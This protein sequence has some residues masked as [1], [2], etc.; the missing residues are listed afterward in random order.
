MGLLAKVG[1][2]RP[3]LRAWVAYDWANSA[4]WTTVIAAVFPIYF[5]RVAADGLA[6]EVAAFR[7]GIATTIALALIAFVSPPLGALADAAG[8]KKRMLAVFML[9]GALAT[10]ALV[11]VRTGD[12]LLAL[13]LFMA[14]N[15]GAAGSMTFYD[16][17]LPH[18][19]RPDELDRVSTT[20]Y[21]VGYLGGG[22]LLALNLLWIQK[23]EWFGFAD[24]GQATRASFLSVAVWWI[25]FTLPLMR[26]VPEPPVGGGPGGASVGD[27]FRRIGRTLGELR[28]YRHAFLMLLAFLI[29]NDGIQTIIRMASL[30]GTQVGIAEGSLIAALL[31]VQFVGIPCALVFGRLAGAIG[32]KR[33]IFASLVIYGGISVLAFYMTQA[34]Q[35]FALAFLVGTVQG[36]SQG[37][38]RS[39][40]ARLIPRHKS[41]EFFGFFGV[42]EKFAGIFGPLL[43]ALAVKLTGSSRAAILSVMAFFVVG[44]LILARVDIEEG[45]RIADEE[46]ARMDAEQARLAGP[47]PRPIG[48]AT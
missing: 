6:P 30:Y 29:Y 28:H 38:S 15:I 1:L 34:W 26:R 37:L 22:V 43:F 27:A 24:S 3:E 16:S 12:W 19:A 33:A 42:F 10:A 2:G 41:S 5:A 47:A 35:F 21:A 48:D 44:G 8:I 13:V 7:F 23:P 14:G 18:V 36:G 40:F 25:V 46:N 17:L 31:L 32:A 45:R 4:Y 20:G 9:I 39:L 11:F